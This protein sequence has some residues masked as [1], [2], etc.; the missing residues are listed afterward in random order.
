MN[1][2][3]GHKIKALEY[4]SDVIVGR[5]QE[6]L[7]RNDKRKGSNRKLHVKGVDLA[8]IPRDCHYRTN[9]IEPGILDYF[10]VRIVPI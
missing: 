6:F 5:E 1:R 7:R 8:K 2:R 10:G 9:Y 4:H 3:K